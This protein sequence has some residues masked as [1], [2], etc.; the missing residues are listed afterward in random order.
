MQNLLAEFSNYGVELRSV[1]GFCSSA[2][3]LKTWRKS[4]VGPDL[5]L[6]YVNRVFSAISNIICNAQGKVRHLILEHLSNEPAVF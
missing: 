3:S 1:G 6:L 2:V 5:S 4:F